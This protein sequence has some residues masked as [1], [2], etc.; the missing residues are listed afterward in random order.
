LIASV[1]DKVFVD[2]DEGGADG[3][4]AGGSDAGSDD[5][6]TDG[7]VE[8]ASSD[9]GEAGASDAS[10]PESDSG[11][12][13][14][15][16]DASTE[17]GARPD[18]Q[19]ADA[20]HADEVPDATPSADSPD[21]FVGTTETDSGLIDSGG[22]ATPSPESSTP[23]AG[24]PPRTIAVVSGTS[25]DGLE[26]ICGPQ[27]N[28]HCCEVLEVP[29]GQF[30][31]G[32]TN[33]QPSERPE[34]RAQV[35][36]FWLDRYEVT[37]GRFKAFADDYENWHDTLGNPKL[38]SGQHP[39][40]PEASWSDERWFGVIP[41]AAN[42]ESYFGIG[43]FIRQHPTDSDVVQDALPVTGVDWFISYAFCIWAGGRLPTEA[44][45][46]FASAGPEDLTYPWG[47]NGST[48][49]LQE[50]NADCSL[51]GIP[52][53]CAWTDIAEV[54]HY[55]LGR[56]PFGHDDLSGNVYEWVFDVYAEDWYVQFAD[57][58][59][60]NN[61]VNVGDG[62]R[63]LK[64]GSF[65]PGTYTMESYSRSFDDAQDQR[66]NLGFRCAYDSEPAY[67]QVSP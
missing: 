12:D 6:S 67:V 17:G 25:C 61:C 50:A 32:D 27:R 60:C 47:N 23:E 2:P 11:A 54:G 42:F 65:D 45:R 64:G 16:G 48:G 22:E 4:D 63:V 43:T 19:V 10:A 56:G 13:G 55:P 35:N 24:P 20:G 14:G 49:L 5:E 66:Y 28:Q 29:D 31:M 30:D 36:A 9:A 39:L 52:E 58:S 57:G 33:G 1:D 51:D 44:E 34:H 26:P 40:N 21:A 38:N 7:G 3:S 18:A 41:R 8:D 46:E 59:L 37:V 53:E 15:P 62:Q